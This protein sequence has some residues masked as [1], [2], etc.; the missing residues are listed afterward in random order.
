MEA[1]DFVNINDMTAVRG[2]FV[3]NPLGYLDEAIA[4]AEAN[5]DMSFPSTACLLQDRLR[6]AVE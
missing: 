6:L 4:I 2:F 1:D 5:P 3:A